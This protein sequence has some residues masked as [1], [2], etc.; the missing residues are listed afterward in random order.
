[1]FCVV[2]VND[3]TYDFTG[4]AAPHKDDSDEDGGNAAAIGVSVVLVVIVIVVIVGAVLFWMY[5]K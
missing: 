2:A 3:V 4:G 1:M 5:K